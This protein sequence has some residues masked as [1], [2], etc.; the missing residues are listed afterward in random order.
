V[1]AGLPVTGVAHDAPPTSVVGTDVQARVPSGLATTA[2]RL[3]GVGPSVEFRLSR[4]REQLASAGPISVLDRATSLDFW[5]EIRD[6]APLSRDP[7]CSLWRISV[8]PAQG[9]E[10]LARLLASVPDARAFLDWGG[11]LIW[12]QVPNGDGS[13]GADAGA[14]ARVGAGLA[15]RANGALAVGQAT[16]A[17]AGVSAYANAVRAALAHSGGHATLVRAPIEVRRALDVFQPQTDA[18]AALSAR[19]KQQFDP[20]R[21]L[22]PGRMYAGV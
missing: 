22:N 4:L 10:V 7:A 9:A 17:G 15:A 21:V 12:L 19:V 6:V 20:Q 2:F 11:G 5:R 16:N 3:E 8:P 18:L 1:G 13:E 14:N